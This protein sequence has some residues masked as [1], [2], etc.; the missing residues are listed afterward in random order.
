MEHKVKHT[1]YTFQ[2]TKQIITAR[3]VIVNGTEKC[4]TID[5]KL[6]ETDIQT[7]NERQEGK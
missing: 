6:L 5:L 3:N 2:N 4:E 1:K 7:E